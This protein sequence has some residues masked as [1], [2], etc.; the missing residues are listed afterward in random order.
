MEKKPSF[1]SEEQFEEKQDLHPWYF[2]QVSDRMHHPMEQISALRNSKQSV[3]RVARNFYQNVDIIIHNPQY[4]YV[5]YVKHEDPNR[6]IP[7][8][9]FP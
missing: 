9:K 1:I 8:I 7:T 3:R 5:D 4:P 6:R 2:A